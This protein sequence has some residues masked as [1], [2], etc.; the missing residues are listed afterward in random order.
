MARRFAGG[1]RDAPD[2][3]YDEGDVTRHYAEARAVPQP[4][5]A[6]PLAKVAEERG[7]RGTLSKVVRTYHGEP[8]IYEGDFFAF[9]TV[10]G[11]HW[12]AV[13]AEA[14]PGMA[15][16]GLQGCPEDFVPMSLTE[17]F[18]RDARG[19]E[20]VEDV[21]PITPDDPDPINREA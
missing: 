16:D 8:D 18:I 1:F 12:Y 5:P 3:T 14:R 21:E 4:E 2:G 9:G 11:I 15:F 6:H 19:W 17:A 20:R 13:P 10:D 7:L